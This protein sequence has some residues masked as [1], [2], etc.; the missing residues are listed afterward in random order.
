[1]RSMKTTKKAGEM[2]KVDEL[3]KEIGREDKGEEEVRL[4]PRCGS[5][6]ISIRSIDIPGFAPEVY[7]CGNCGFKM[8]APLEA[9]PLKVV[10]VEEKTEKKNEKKSLK[11]K[12]K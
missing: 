1:M 11:K 7:V 9:E 6:K 5:T 8:E 2:E 10:E 4:C 3:V 12:K